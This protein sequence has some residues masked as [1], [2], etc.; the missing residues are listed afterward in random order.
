MC[1]Y[2]CVCMCMYVYVY[3]GAGLI[4]EGGLFHFF[5]RK[6]GLLEG[7]YLGGGLNRE[8]TV[9]YIII[10]SQ[11]ST[12]SKIHTRQGNENTLETM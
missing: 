9:D 2:V 12:C 1:V 6:G 4:R 7:A 11:D 3:C 8:I 5:T 10:H